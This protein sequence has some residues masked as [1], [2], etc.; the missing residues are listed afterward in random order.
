MKKFIVGLFCLLAFNLNAQD[1]KTVTLVVSGQGQTQNEAKQNALRSAIEQAFGTYISS[2]TEILNDDLVKDEIVSVSNG[3]IQNYEVLSEGKIENSHYSISLKATVSVSKL[4]TFIENKGINVEF[5]GDILAE[6]VRLQILNEKNEVESIDNTVKIC[7]DILDRSC[8]FEIVRGEPKQKNSDNL[9]WAVPLKI[10]TKFNSNINLFC[11][12]LT[13]A[14][15]NLSMSEAEILKYSQLGKKTFPIVLGSRGIGGNTGD[16]KYLENMAKSNSELT[17]LVVHRGDVVL[18]SNNFKTIKKEFQKLES[19][20]YRGYT[21][22]QYFETN[23]KVVFHF[24]NLQTVISIIDLINYSQH[25]LLNFK[26]SNGINTIIPSANTPFTILLD[27]LTPIF[28]CREDYSNFKATM[29]GPEGIFYQ[30]ERTSQ[31]SRIWIYKRIE[32]YDKRYYYNGGRN[33]KYNYV[34][35][36]KYPFLINADALLPQEIKGK[37]HELYEFRSER[38]YFAVISLVDYSILNQNVS[39]LYYEDVLSLEEL[40]KIS[41]Y[42][43]TPIQTN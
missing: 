18:K 38:G 34:Y 40:G 11:K 2:K 12:Y 10:K 41:E 33:D 20:N 14:V 5:N 25:A 26:L 36:I 23:N 31:T 37:N 22:I 27:S 4:T 17:Y 29:N 42:N 32:K 13:N 35:N 3:N 7:K 8:D 28:N 1:D 6:N 15:T 16:I 21:Q 30:D 19:G 39:T 9:K 43:I 24:R